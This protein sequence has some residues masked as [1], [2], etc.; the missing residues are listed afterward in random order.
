MT[1]PI[2]LDYQSTTPVDPRV[3]EAMRPFFTESYGNPASSTHAYGW[4]AEEAV[5]AAR[6]QVAQSIGAKPR[7]IVFVSGATEANNLAIQGACLRAPPERQHLVTVRTEHKAVLDTMAAMERRG[8]R[9]TRLPV[10]EEGIVSP[11][12]VERALTP[13][14]LLVS[15]MHANNETGV[16]QPIRAIGELCRAR[17]VLFHTDAAQ[18]AGKLPLDV[19]ADSLD[20]VS[21]SGHKIY[22]PKG[23]GAL[24]VRRAPTVRLAALLHGGGHERGLR[25]GTLSTPLIVGLGVALELAIAERAQEADRLVALRDALWTA[26]HGALPQIHVNGSLTQRLPGNLNVSFAGV[27]GEA[28]LTS[29]PELALSSGSACTSAQLEPSYVLQAMGLQSAAAYSALRFGL[30]RFTT[31]DHVALASERVIAAVRTLRALSPAW[32]QPR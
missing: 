29:L 27:E 26:L 30:G 7:D 2:Y 6:R 19:T 14:T 9:V 18:S 32:S 24:Y 8:F 11:E 20:L 28:L 3:F 22:G 12:Q 10:D 21:I 4:E 5:D 25:S 31:P 17:D 1:R 15:V 23:I 13:S 16:V